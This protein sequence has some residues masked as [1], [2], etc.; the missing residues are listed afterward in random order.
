[1][2]W[3]KWTLKNGLRVLLHHRPRIPKVYYQTLFKVGSRDEK[4]GE[5]GIAHTLE[6]L[7]FKGS[8]N[9]SGKTFNREIE[10]RGIFHNAATSYDYTYYYYDL[11][12]QHLKWLIKVEADR[13][14]WPLLSKKRF[15]R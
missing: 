9:Y 15:K 8:R 4:E 1:M 10:D 2:R 14:G 5:T 7:L 6:H 11:P 3:K 13:M 12:S